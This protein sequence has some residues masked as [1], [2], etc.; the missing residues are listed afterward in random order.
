MLF[1]AKALCAVDDESRTGQHLLIDPPDVLAEDPDADQL[2]APHEKDQ[3]DERGIADGE[4]KS[5]QL[6]DQIGDGYQEGE[7]SDPESQLGAERQGVRGE[8]EDP[9]K[10]DPE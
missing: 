7:A 3:D 5:A 2:D 10:S 8:A 9:V 6:H 1:A 4:G